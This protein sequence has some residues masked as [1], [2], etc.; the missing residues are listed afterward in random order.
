MWR[1][2]LVAILAVVRSRLR[3]QNEVWQ[4]VSETMDCR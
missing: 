3:Y 1:R 2:A 4:E